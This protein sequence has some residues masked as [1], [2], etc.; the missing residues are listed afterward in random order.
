LEVYLKKFKENPPVSPVNILHQ[1]KPSNIKHK[2]E[3]FENENEKLIT[4]I[5]T[6]DDSKFEAQGKSKNSAKINAYK[7]AVRYFSNDKKIIFF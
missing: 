2:I 7:K 5:L 1:L 4:V 6:I 3:S